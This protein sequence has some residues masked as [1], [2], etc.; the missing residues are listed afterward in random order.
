MAGVIG[1]QLDSADCFAWDRRL[2]APFIRISLLLEALASM[3][4]PSFCI[5]L[6]ST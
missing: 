4:F 3:G 5:E 1:G 6:A 2:R